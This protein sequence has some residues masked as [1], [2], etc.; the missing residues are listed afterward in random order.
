MGR[1]LLD[2][3]V[4]NCVNI[5]PTEI[6]ATVF[7]H[8]TPKDIVSA[9]QVCK[10]WC[11]LSENESLWRGN[12]NIQKHLRRLLMSKKID[13]CQLRCPDLPKDEA[14]SWK[15]QFNCLAKVK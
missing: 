14:D 6:I 2:A 7:M 15:Q 13:Y 8:L 1:T 12:I 9:M 4:T 5:L 11:V 3:T 10:R